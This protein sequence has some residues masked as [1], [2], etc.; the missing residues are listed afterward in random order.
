MEK[1]FF[2]KKI[3]KKFLFLK[4]PICEKVPCLRQ[5]MMIYHKMSMSGVYENVFLTSFYDLKDGKKNFWK[6]NLKKNFFLKKTNLWK[7]N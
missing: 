7:S 1:K 2:E 6:K 4:K 3:R 5:K